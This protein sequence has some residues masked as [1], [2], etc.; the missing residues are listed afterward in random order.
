M[1]GTF[2]VSLAKQMQV[3]LQNQQKFRFQPIA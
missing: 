3:D 2:S 1:A